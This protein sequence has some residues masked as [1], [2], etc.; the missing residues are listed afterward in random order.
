MP[1]FNNIVSIVPYFVVAAVDMA[2]YRETATLI[3]Y[4]V[5]AVDPPYTFV[6][7]LYFI[8]ATTTIAE[9]TYVLR[10]AASIVLTPAAMNS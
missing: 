10:Q 3:H 4:I 5:A 8:S 9:I 7:A 2:G 6:G 1:A